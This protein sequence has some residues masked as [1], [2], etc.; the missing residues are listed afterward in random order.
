[1][2]FFF[3]S[4]ARELGQQL[5]VLIALGKDPGLVPVLGEPMTF[6]GFC[7]HQECMYRQTHTI[8]V[9]TSLKLIHSNLMV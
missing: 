4:R 8:K 1:L 3:Y 9:N 7:W 2:V 5:K 6:P